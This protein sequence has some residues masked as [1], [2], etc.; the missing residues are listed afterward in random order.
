[1]NIQRFAGDNPI[2]QKMA[3]QVD[4]NNQLMYRRQSEAMQNA[5]EQR[6]RDVRATGVSDASSYL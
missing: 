6:A 1:M 3:Q 2:M 5:Y 4:A